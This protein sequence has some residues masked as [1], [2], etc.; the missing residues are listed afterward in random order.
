MT[1]LRLLTAVTFCALI[2]G[3]GPGPQGP[4]G[5]AGTAGAPGEKGDPGPNGPPGPPGPAGP[6]G[7]PGPASAIRILRTDCVASACT[8][9]CAS[10]E[11]LVT[12]YCGATRSPATFLTERSASCGVIANPG[13][14]P[15]VMVCAAS[16]AAQ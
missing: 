9:E 13:N 10:N 12:A 4:Q 5:P 8:A 14:S 15:L 16:A 1:I 6:A 7:P 11:V 2:A 3:C